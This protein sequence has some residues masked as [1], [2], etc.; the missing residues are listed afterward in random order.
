MVDLNRQIIFNQQECTNS[1]VER[2]KEIMIIING[3]KNTLKYQNQ[4]YAV[5]DSVSLESTSRVIVQDNS[6]RTLCDLEK[7]IKKK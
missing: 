6:Y 2:E 1:I 5:R 7:K 4:K 3:M